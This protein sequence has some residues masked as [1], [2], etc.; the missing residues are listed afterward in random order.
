MRKI[1]FVGAVLGVI[2]PYFFIF[3]FLS[4]YGFNLSLMARQVFSSPTPAFL[5]S[6]LIICSL[7]LW[8]FVF[9]EGR[10]QG[11]RNLWVYILLNL[12]V[13]VPLALAVFL[14]VREGKKFKTL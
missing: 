8:A 2:L 3:Q 11:M 14:W 5:G 9:S 12:L 1:Y 6:D 13:G 7:V 4:L 10:R